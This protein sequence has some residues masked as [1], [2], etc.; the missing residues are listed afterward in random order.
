M[1]DFQDVARTTAAS[2]VGDT[3]RS[4]TNVAAGANHL[5]RAAGLAAPTVATGG[6][7]VFGDATGKCIDNTFTLAQPFV[8]L[9]RLTYIVT[10]DSF[11]LCDKSAPDSWYFR[12][13]I[14][15]M[16]FKG[17]GADRYA[18][19]WTPDSTPRVVGALFNGASSRTYSDG[20]V[21][22]ATLDGTGITNGLRVGCYNPGIPN[23]SWPGAMTDWGIWSGVFTD[24]DLDAMAAILEAAP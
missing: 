23:Y 7:L 2:S 20:V 10:G 3:V 21:T 13:Q 14:G 22:A 4:A 24:S 5:T 8:V 9:V 17:P 15:R 6:G 12:Q 1:S 19:L 16:Y 18:T 11:P